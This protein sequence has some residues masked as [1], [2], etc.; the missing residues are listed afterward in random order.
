MSNLDSIN[1]LV[2]SLLF[3]IND[4]LHLK[5][6]WSYATAETVVVAVAKLPKSF[7]V[8]VASDSEPVIVTPDPKLPV[9]SLK[10]NKPLSLS[11]DTKVPETVVE[12][13]SLIPVIVS[14]VCK[15]TWFTCY[16]KFTIHR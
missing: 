15:C 12:P 16:N 9:T 7:F 13:S 4:H 8:A 2:F 10:V 11:N 1:Y 14:L 3:L 6:S 5:K